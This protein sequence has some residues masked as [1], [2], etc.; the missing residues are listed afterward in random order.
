MLE[1]FMKITILFFCLHLII[2]SHKSYGIEP[3]AV[4][5]VHDKLHLES[6]DTTVDEDN[7]KTTSN[8]NLFQ[9]ED[10]FVREIDF[11][12]F[13]KTG[14]LV[15]SG[16][17]DSIGRPNAV[18]P[19]AAGNPILDKYPDKWR[20]TFQTQQSRFGFSIL[21]KEDITGLVEF[22]FMDFSKSTPTVA[23]QIRLRRA[24][25]NL[26]NGPW[27]F[28]IGQDWDL[29]SPLGPHSY[30]YIGHYFG[31]GDLGF[32]RQQLQ[33]YKK[34]NQWEHAIAIGYPTNNNQMMISNSELALVPTLALRE[35]YKFNKANSLGFS[36]IVGHLKNHDTT[37]TLSPFGLNAFFKKISSSLEISSEIYYGHN[38][39]NLRFITVSGGM[40]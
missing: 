15:S 1:D 13:I 19:T 21:A 2:M 28:R 6:I 12:G 16:A 27:S 9:N 5:P 24:Y 17:T 37:E 4:A 38:L 26:E 20:S 22:D 32:M 35:T 33:I 18:A 10:S 8:H 34:K 40:R 23:S 7:K 31:S 36:A 39:E 14:V 11:F 3:H 29:F 25:I 30:N